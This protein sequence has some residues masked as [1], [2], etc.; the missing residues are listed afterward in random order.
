MGDFDEPWEQ[1]GM[2][3]GKWLSR[4][5]SASSRRSYATEE[6]GSFARIKEAATYAATQEYNSYSCAMPKMFVIMT[7]SLREMLDKACIGFKETESA[8]VFS[9]SPWP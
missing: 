2:P 1:N 6:L 9:W 5:S 4:E 3:L 8:Y 7:P